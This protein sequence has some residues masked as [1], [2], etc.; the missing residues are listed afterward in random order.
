MAVIIK[1]PP[2]EDAKVGETIKEFD[3]GRLHVKVVRTK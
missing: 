3:S 1:A 2:G